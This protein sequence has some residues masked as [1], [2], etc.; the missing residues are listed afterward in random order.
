MLCEISEDTYEISRKHIHRKICILVIFSCVI[1][2]IFQNWDRA[3]EIT[4][5]EYWVLTA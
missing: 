5:G 3:S 1:Y 4:I 2:D